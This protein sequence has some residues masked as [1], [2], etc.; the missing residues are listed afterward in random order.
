MSLYAT[1][2]DPGFAFPGAFSPRGISD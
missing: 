2:S 1:L